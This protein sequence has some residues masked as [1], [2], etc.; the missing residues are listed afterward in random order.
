MCWMSVCRWYLDQFVKSTSLPIGAN[1][2]EG[3]SQTVRSPIRLQPRTVL[4]NLVSLLPNYC[5][6]FCFL[7]VPQTFRTE[8]SGRGA[9]QQL[10]TLF[11]PS[12]KQ[13][14]G[15]VLLD[16]TVGASLSKLKSHLTSLWTVTNVYVLLISVIGGGGGGG[17][18]REYKGPPCWERIVYA[19]HKT[20]VQM[21][22]RSLCNGCK[23][24][25]HNKRDSLFFSHNCTVFWDVRHCTTY[26]KKLYWTWNMFNFA[27]SCLSEIFVI[28]V[29]T[30]RDTRINICRSS[31]K[32]SVI[33][34]DFTKLKCLQI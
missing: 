28:M 23:E 31:C 17:A 20:A 5:F 22:Q 4:L 10:L 8:Y 14:V 33:L 13:I 11:V 19:V 6:P 2:A 29:N 34:S 30:E 3:R 21:I 9:S 18:G 24:T 25:C 32:V 16:A 1:G 12:M 15:W 7:S 27:L 26:W